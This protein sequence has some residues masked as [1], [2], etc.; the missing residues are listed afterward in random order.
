MID[1]KRLDGAWDVPAWPQPI[2]VGKHRLLITR[3]SRTS[4]QRYYVD[5]LETDVNGYLAITG[6][7]EADRVARLLL[8][9]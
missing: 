3:N 9:Q 1:T 6:K 7:H 5:G 8:R 2:I 4:E